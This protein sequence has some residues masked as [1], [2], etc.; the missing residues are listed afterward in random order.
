LVNYSS[1]V[2]DTTFAALADP[3]RRAMLA[4]LASG[5]CSISE[6]AEPFEISL[7]AVSKHVRVLED[8][9]LLVRE[10]DGRV[11]RC[12]IDPAP[13][14]AATAWLEDMRRFWESR[15]DALAGYIDQ[16][17][18]TEWPEPKQD[19]QR[20]SKSGGSTKRRPPK[21]SG[22]GPTRKR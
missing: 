12:N 5:E 16:L 1:S 8:A 2:L 17:E 3:T 4:R 9:G 20:A 6:L 14:A 22:R 18:E 13:I 19:P 11:H 10:R 15:L 7:P 21:S